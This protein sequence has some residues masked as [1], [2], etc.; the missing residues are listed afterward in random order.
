LET[1]NRISFSQ[2]PLLF[3]TKYYLSQAAR[4]SLFMREN[5]TRSPMENLK[6]M[7]LKAII[8]TVLIALSFHS[9]AQN[10]EFQTFAM[11]HDSIMR[12]AYDQKNSS[13]YLASYNEFDQAFNKLSDKDKAYFRG[14][15]IAALYNLSCTYS[16]LNDKKNAIAYLKRSIDAGWQDFAHIQKDADL[17]NIRK[18]ASFE[19]IMKP[20][21]EVYDYLYILKK[22]GK[23]NGAEKQ[24]LPAFTYQSYG[25]ANLKALRQAFNLDSIAGTANEVS[26]IIN[27]MRWVHNLVPHDGNHANPVVKN[28][29]SMIA[30]CKRDVRGL[31]CRGLATVLNECY[32]AMGIRSRFVTCL[33]KDSLHNDPDCHVIN[34]VYSTE[35]KKWLWMDPTNN[36][37]VMNEKG[38]LLGIEEVRERLIND[39][40]LLLNPD[41]NWNNRSTVTKEYYLYQYMAKNLYML[42]CPVS[43]EYDTETKDGG[44]TISYLRLVPL[45]YFNKS[46]EKTSATDEK[47]KSTNTTFRTN[48]PAFF[49]QLP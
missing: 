2:K 4:E 36:A 1:A 41:A 32:L 46:I 17:D 49:W 30:E 5:L 27:L 38:E 19:A 34:M 42:E 9:F 10:P 48:N 33:P 37:Y 28:A 8:C 45:D 29:L 23:Y 6:P 24:G 26:K 31:N 16:L 22:A 7:N 12:K 18:E 25:N 13:I 47:T 39:K 35:L 3:S 43:S 44:K 11:R 15:K 21:R 40:P 14:N 20:F